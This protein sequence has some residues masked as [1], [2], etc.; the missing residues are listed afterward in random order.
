MGVGARDVVPARRPPG[1]DRPDR[2]VGDD[3][4]VRGGARGQAALELAVEHLER[5]A[6]RATCASV[7]PM[8]RIGIRPAASAA[9]ALA[10][11]SGVALAV[12]VAPLGVADDHRLTA[13]ILEH[14]RR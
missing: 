10:R 14:R 5:L 7:S 3:Q 4:S 12:A 11:T 13:G 1:A 8:H 9:S 6:G 2:L